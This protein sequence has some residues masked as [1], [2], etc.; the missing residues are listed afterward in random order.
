MDQHGN[1]IKFSRINQM[2]GGPCFDE[3]EDATLYKFDIK[4]MDG[5]YGFLCLD[6]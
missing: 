3:I 5:G 6:T 4:H 1:D 2:T